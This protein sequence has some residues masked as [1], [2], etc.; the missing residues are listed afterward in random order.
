MDDGYT[1]ELKDVFHL[2]PARRFVQL[3]YE[4]HAIVDPPAGHLKV[5]AWEGVYAVSDGEL[6]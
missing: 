1:L 2:L 5:R 6:F 3:A 4:E